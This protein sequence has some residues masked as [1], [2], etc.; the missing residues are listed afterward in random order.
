M[1][2]FRFFTNSLIFVLI[3]SAFAFAQTVPANKI[4]VI[5]TEVFYD[6]EKGIKEIVETNDKLETEFKP[7]KDELLSLAEKLK[8]LEEEL[9]DVAGMIESPRDIGI[10]NEMIDGKVKEYDSAVE[11]Y[12]KRLNDVKSLYD[13]RKPVIFADVYKK[14]GEAIKQFMKEKGYVLILDNSKLTSGLILGDLDDV[15]KEFIKYY[16][17]NF[18][19]TE[20]R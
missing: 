18:A 19:G 16:N 5:D 6:K 20:T 15:T 14:V 1:K 9:K 13:K 11:N 2:G 3:L 12:K 8:V 17:D 7:Q 4:A 10:T